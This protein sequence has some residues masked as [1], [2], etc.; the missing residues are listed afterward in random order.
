MNYVGQV[1]KLP[2]PIVGA[3]PICPCCEETQMETESITRSE[4]HYAWCPREV[5]MLHGV[6]LLVERDSALVVA[7]FVQPR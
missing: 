6:T 1:L 3:N 5:C 2:Y 7:Q 4:I